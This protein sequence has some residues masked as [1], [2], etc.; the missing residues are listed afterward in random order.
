MRVVLVDIN[1][2]VV[3]HWAKGLGT[4]VRSGKVSLQHGSLEYFK[5]NGML[6]SIVSPGNSFGFLG[7]GFDLAI[8]EY[9]GGALFERYVRYKLMHS[10][11]PVTNCTVIPLEQFGRDDFQY[12]LHIPTVVT[13]VVP[14]F[15]RRDPVHTGYRIVFD[16]TWNA[17]H[18]APGDTEQ[19][20]IPG[21]CTGYA[22]VPIPVACKAMCFAIRLFYL[23]KTLSQDLINTMIMCFMGYQYGPFISEDCVAECEKMRV[24]WDTLL[25]FNPH[26]DELDSILPPGH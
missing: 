5:P 7:G 26:T 1:V 2:S 3:S 14:D 13:P 10:Y 12:L 4:L 8:Q 22:G 20:V 18:S 24:D 21:L 19:L 23:E 15:D 9:F 6:K 17:L 16:V 11:V 25:G